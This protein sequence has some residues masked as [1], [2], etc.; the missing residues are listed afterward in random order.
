MGTLRQNDG[1]EDYFPRVSSE[2]EL[3]KTHL[4]T[5]LHWFAHNCITEFD[6]IVLSCKFY[7]LHIIFRKNYARDTCVI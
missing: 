3:Y 2:G 1:V 7:F 6:G 5:L 4:K